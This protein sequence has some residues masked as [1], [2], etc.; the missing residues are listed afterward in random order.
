MA[1]KTHHDAT[2]KPALK[3]FSQKLQSWMV[4]KNMSR[5]DFLYHCAKNR[6]KVE[7][8][9]LSKLLNGRGAS[10]TLETA[11]RYAQVFGLTLEEFFCDK[12]SSALEK[13]F[14]DE[15]S[16]FRELLLHGQPDDVKTIRQHIRLVLRDVEERKHA[17]AR[18]PDVGKERSG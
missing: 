15:F 17:Q 6:N 8:G 10:P 9:R 3:W 11:A 12:E 1:K 18:A 16:A 13:K 2:E 14:A 5:K 7:G 4:R